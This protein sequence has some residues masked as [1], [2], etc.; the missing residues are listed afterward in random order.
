MEQD[1]KYIVVWG[2]CTVL[3]LG[4][5]SPGGGSGGLLRHG[6]DFGRFGEPSSGTALAP[7]STALGSVRAS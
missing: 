6:W 5:W 3:S 4:T 2:A 7:G 1:S